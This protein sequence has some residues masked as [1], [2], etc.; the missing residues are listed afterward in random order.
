VRLAATVA[1]SIPAQA[2]LGGITVLT[3]LNPWT[4]AAHFMLSMGII[5]LAFTLWA[6]VTDRPALP[7]RP[8]VRSAGRGLM[9]LTAA[10]LVLGTIVTGSGPHAGDVKNGKV[11]RTGLDVGSMS[12]L[13]A[14]AVMLLIGATI[15]VAVLLKVT[16]SDRRLPRSAWVLLAVE[17]GQGLIGFVQYFAHVPP[18][19]VG[20]H[21]FGACLVWLAALDVGWR[22]GRVT[23]VGARPTESRP[24]GKSELGRPV[25]ST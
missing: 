21:M 20:L 12:Q 18:L 15:G 16:A 9:A 5:A 19:L 13:H 3:H 6:R 4:V 1:A 10:V 17:L 11:R 7:V 24:A 23:V 25:V 2:L 8:A 22:S 14:D